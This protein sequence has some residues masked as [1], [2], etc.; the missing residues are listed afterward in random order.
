[1]YN[2]G[3]CPMRMFLFTVY[4]N[5][6]QNSQLTGRVNMVNNYHI[7]TCGFS[8]KIELNVSKYLVKFNTRLKILSN[9][10]KCQYFQKIDSSK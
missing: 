4:L 1:M 7:Y 3:V 5:K 8:L 9:T 6:L 10:Q 2:S